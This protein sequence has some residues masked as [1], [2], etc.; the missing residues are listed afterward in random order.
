M[1]AEQIVNAQR[2]Y[3]VDFKRRAAGSK[4]E[5]AQAKEEARQR[6]IAAGI[7]ERDGQLATPYR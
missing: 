3:L 6:L 4:Q 1:T 7:I 2:Q 5:Q